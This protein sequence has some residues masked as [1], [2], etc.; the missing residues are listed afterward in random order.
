LFVEEGLMAILS[1]PLFGDEARGTVG[2]L[3]TFKRSAVH[4][5]AGAFTDHPVNWTTGKIAQASAWKN[6]CNQWRALS[7]GERAT[8]RDMAPVVLTGFNYFMQLGGVV[9]FPPC[10]EV[11][12]GNELF[13]DFICGTYSPPAGDS[14][15][16][17]WEE[18]I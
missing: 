5:V 15:S 9:P 1:E 11:P 8:W 10:Y 12:G 14:L 18:C 13:F 6:G 2:Q 17:N 7:D 4:P 3:L 16:F